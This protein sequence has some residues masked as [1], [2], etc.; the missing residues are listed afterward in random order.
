LDD[1]VEVPPD[2]IKAGDNLRVI[3]LLLQDSEFDLGQ[4]QDLANVVMQIRGQTAALT[5]FRQGK[6]RG[7]S[8]EPFLLSGNLR[9][10]SYST[11]KI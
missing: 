8:S 1:L 3:Q 2:L 11:K 6:F 7:Q 10:L 4:G 9:L 5:L